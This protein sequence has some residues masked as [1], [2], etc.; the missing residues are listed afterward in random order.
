MPGTAGEERRA[1]LPRQHARPS[2]LVGG[3][4]A[5]T[6]EMIVAVFGREG[7]F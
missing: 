3:D 2:M 7:T 5:A 6:S 4:V 1:E